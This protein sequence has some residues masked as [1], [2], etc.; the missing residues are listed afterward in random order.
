MNTITVTYSDG[1]I[2]APFTTSFLGQNMYTLKVLPIH[3]R[4]LGTIDYQTIHRRLG[5]PSK[6]VVR[7]AKQHTSGLPDFTIPENTTVYP[8][9]AKGKQP[10]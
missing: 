10:Q 5:H 4:A 9:C 2:Q 6:E 7:Q 8:G 3:S 1:D